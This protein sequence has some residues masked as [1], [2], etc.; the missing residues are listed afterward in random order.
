MLIAPCAFVCLLVVKIVC[1]GRRGRV[2]VAPVQSTRLST[3]TAAPL[4][5]VTARKHLAPEKTSDDGLLNKMFVLL[6]C[7]YPFLSVRRYPT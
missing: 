6:F 7:I 5:T 4:T 1:S 3:S 2:R